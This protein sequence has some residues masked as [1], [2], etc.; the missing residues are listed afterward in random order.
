MKWTT[1]R[2]DIDLSTPLVMGIVNVTPDSFSDGGRFEGVKNALAHAEQLI[3]DGADILD[4]GGESTRPGSPAVSLQEELLRLLPVVKE[5]VKLGVPI[6]VDTYKAQVMREVLDMG[7]DIIND[8]WALRQDGARQVVAAHPNCGVCLMHMH[9]TPQ[10]MHQN[11]MQ[12]DAVPEVLGFL[13]EQ[14]KLLMQ[15]GVSMSRLVVDPGVGFGKSVTQ[16]FSLLARQK[17][18]AALDL[19]V[20]AGWSRK[21]SLG[22]VTGL[23]V[24]Q[25]VL[26]SVVAAVLAVERGAKIV[27][28]HD[29]AETKAGLKVWA[30][31][32]EQDSL[33]EAVLR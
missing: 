1:S 31:M 21:G 24:E 15:A 18:F 14:M 23:P 22:A 13:R 25:R 33:S 27:R 32:H 10:S 30:A 11:H 12:G 3:Q 6:S 19:P 28:V 29:V 4:F 16:N 26:P 9:M 8:V 2:F 20:L 5:A 17:E 7:V